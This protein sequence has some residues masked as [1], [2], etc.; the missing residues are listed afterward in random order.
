MLGIG[1]PDRAA[2]IRRADGAVLVLMGMLVW[3]GWYIWAGF[4]FLSGLRHP[5]PLDDVTKLDSAR[6]LIGFG[7]FVLFALT[8][9]P[10]PFPNP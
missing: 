1:L 5:T 9:I 10:A 3:R 2:C 7:A 4:I 8:L 6:V